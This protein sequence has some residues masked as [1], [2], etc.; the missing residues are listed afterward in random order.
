LKRLFVLA[1][2]LIAATVAFAQLTLT[3]LD[4]PTGNLT[5]ARGIN[6]SGDIV[7]AYR[8]PGGG[9][10]HAMIISN[11]VFSP[12]LP[13]SI[14]GSTYSEAFKI[15]DRGDVVG[16]YLDEDGLSHGFLVTKHGTL[17]LLDFPGFTQSRATG[18]NNSGT[19]VGWGDILDA[20]GNLLAYHGFTWK[21]GVFTQ[22]DFATGGDTAVTGINERGD[23]VGAYDTGVT[24]PIGHG[25]VIAGKQ[26]I[27]FD[28]PVSG[29]LV[30][31]FND[32]SA[33]GEIVGT[34]VEADGV[35]QHAFLLVGSQFTQIDFPG[36]QLIT[37]AWGINSAGQIVGN[38]QVTGPPPHGFL[39]Q[40][41]KKGK[42]Q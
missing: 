18:I 28:V 36:A 4:Y 23:L 2:V 26:R 21:D 13:D 9:A 33:K 12:L 14:L 40:P 32:I 39:A 24:D 25:F 19:V 5:T 22:I 16:Q 30:S 6:N 41:V 11:G 42:P 1:F 8:L 17:T 34:F 15:N 27:S 10:R 29:V 35:T 31:Q 3:S 37:T 7:G 20:D 38:Y